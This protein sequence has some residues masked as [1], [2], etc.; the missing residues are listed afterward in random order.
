MNVDLDK[1]F[2]EFRGQYPKI[3]DWRGLTPENIVNDKIKLIIL[4]ILM[5]HR[6]ANF[7]KY[8]CGRKELLYGGI[9]NNIPNNLSRHKIKRY[10]LCGFVDNFDVAEKVEELLCSKL[11][12][13]IGKRGKNSA[14]NGG[15]NEDS[16]TDSRVVYIADKTI[17]GFEP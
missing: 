6:L 3:Q 14:G 12:I 16:P 10:L 5:D 17:P 15:K 1:V 7:P 4:G 9:T 13:S 8:S 2:E 11:E